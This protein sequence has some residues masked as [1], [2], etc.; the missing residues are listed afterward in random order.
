VVDGVPAGRR[1]FLGSQAVISEQ[2]FDVPAEDR[3]KMLGGTLAKIMGFDT[4]KKFAPI[5][6][7]SQPASV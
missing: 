2:M 7:S 6:P 3:A 5:T 1:T 4:A